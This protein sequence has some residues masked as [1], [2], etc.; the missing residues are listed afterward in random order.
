MAVVGDVGEDASRLMSLGHVGGLEGIGARL[1]LPCEAVP[2]LPHAHSD[3]QP[4]QL[5]GTS[6]YGTC[7]SS[8]ETEVGSP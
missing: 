5:E 4:Q 6:S 7:G 3:G 2:W 8:T 1:E